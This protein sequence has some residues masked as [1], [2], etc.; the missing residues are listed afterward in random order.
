MSVLKII[1]I[2]LLIILLAIVLIAA[3][4]LLVP[5]RYGADGEIGEKEYSVR[6][7]W[8]FRAVGFTFQS[9]GGEN[10]YFLSLFGRRTRFLD[11]DYREEKKRKRAEKKRK[12][13]LRKKKREDRKRKG[14]GENT[15]ADSETGS[16]GSGRGNDTPSEMREA[17]GETATGENNRK[18]AKTSAE[19]APREDIHGNPNPAE[20]EPEKDNSDSGSGGKVKKIFSILKKVWKG[21][22]EHHPLALAAPKLQKFLY[23]IRPRRLEADLVFGFA[24]P[25][26]TGKLLGAVSNL[27]FLY[28]YEDFHLSGDFETEKNYIDGNFHVQGYLRLAALAALLLGL[29]REKE[30]RLFLKSL[31]K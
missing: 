17:A 6:L 11:P 20:N 30:F 31:K 2:V 15:G 8:L 3:V 7:T 29:I 19:E 28:Q 22:R 4:I 21:M 25:S 1:G 24:D 27:Y 12:K 9:S 26:R 13:A 10:D 5:I 14:K 23:R 18:D 16:V